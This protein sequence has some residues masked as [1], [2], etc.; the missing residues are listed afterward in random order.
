MFTL[1]FDEK[2]EYN[3][4]NDFQ[5]MLCNSW[6]LV[7]HQK[8]YTRCSTELYEKDSTEV[9]NFLKL[10]NALARFF[11]VFQLVLCWMD[12][13]QRQNSCLRYS[14]PRFENGCY[15]RWKLNCNSRIVQAHQRTI[16]SYVQA[17]GKNKLKVEL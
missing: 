11:P 14:T 7:G 12:P 5:C 15:L 2:T 13:Q 1:Y 3:N 8:R 9:W 6:W 4:Y 16:H 17:Q 10:W